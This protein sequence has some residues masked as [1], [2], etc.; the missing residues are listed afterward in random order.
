M[1]NTL[2]P[3]RQMADLH[4]R[5]LA[6][7]TERFTFQTFTDCPAKRD[8]Y[9]AKGIGDPLARILH[10]SLAEHW[11][12]LAKLSSAGAGIY[13]TVNETDLDG[14]SR[15][16][17]LQVRAYFGDLDGAS[18]SNLTRMPLR[19]HFVV[20]S[21]PG[22][23]HAY[24]M[25]D[26]ARLG[27]FKPTQ[28]RLARLID[29][30]LKVCDLPRV[31]RLAG[32]PHQKDPAQ[33][34]SVTIAR[35]QAASP[36][37][38][39]D[40][41]FQAALAAA[42]GAQ[43][44]S[45]SPRDFTEGLASSLGNPPPDMR[46][47]YPDGQRTGELTRRAGYCLGPKNM[48]A[49]QAV[50]ACLDWNCHN[51]P[52]L[53]NEKVRST[54]CSIAKAEA[55][56]RQA[57]A[58]DSHSSK[59]SGDRGVA[60]QANMG[61][62]GASA[63]CDGAE[64][65]SEPGDRATFAALAR[66]SRVEYDRC[67]KEAAKQLGITLP[68]LDKEVEKLREQSAE[69]DHELPHWK[70]EPWADTVDGAGLLDDIRE[71]FLKHVV[72][73]EHAADALALWVLHAWTMNAFDISPFL[74]LSSPEPRCGK[75]TVLILLYWL[76]PR[77]ELAS[78]ISPAAI[79]R[80]IEEVQPTLLI[81]EVDTFVKDNEE[82][83]GILNSGHTRAAAHVIRVVGDDHKPRRFSTWAPKVMAGIGYLANTLRDRSIIVAMRRKTK[84]E[85][86]RKLRGRDTAEFQDL[87]RK[88][89]RWADDNS[90]A[91]ESADP[92]LPQ[93]LNDRA[94][95]NWVPLIA[96]ADL[97]G[98]HWPLSAR[99]TALKLSGEDAADDG[100]IRVQL[101]TD[102]RLAFDTR[103]TDRISTTDLLSDLTKDSERPWAEWRHGRPMNARQLA[104]ILRS[105][106]IFS[107]S[108][109]IGTATP[110]GYLRSNFEDAWNRY[111][112]G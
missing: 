112:S 1:S 67:R 68:T 108:V 45:S 41:E 100:S 109:R 14:R 9:R 23:Y 21:S 40:A 34:F 36:S 37:P 25:V 48:S 15:E 28:Q 39:S 32:L 72:L 65:A 49:E 102:I 90:K 30:D 77:S 78:N 55:R 73:P 103:N 43:L 92:L 76:T 97:M 50:E 27:H 107:D 88:A 4:L 2:T 94:S 29:G 60:E 6:P 56:R 59:Q 42:E 53:S 104:S 81:D 101:L 69:E 86:V 70:V 63:R 24:W 7:S 47:G 18:L 44:K 83:R 10:G 57:D 26:G 85:S 89:L 46:Q 105:F 22:R 71:V 8:D 52:P 13:V 82:L 75:T 5:F 12:V 61:D 31:M 96:I 16:H 95:D 91:L 99:K 98:N 80:Y 11:S 110:K 58:S 17:V 54:V 79:F 87:R 20:Q 84:G 51:T 106:G 3:N 62:Q 93:E 19:P 74:V 33:P 64:A 66:L 38:Y 35:V 111:L